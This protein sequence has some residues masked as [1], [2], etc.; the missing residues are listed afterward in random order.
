MFSA[1]HLHHARVPAA[2][3]AGALL[4]VAVFGRGLE[5]L[6]HFDDVVISD[7]DSCDIIVSDTTFGRP[8]DAPLLVLLSDGAD[9]FEVIAAGARGAISRNSSPSR[10]HAA[11]QAIGEGLIV[12]DR[13]PARDHRTPLIDPLTAREQDVL[14]L[15]A[16]GL[17]NKEIAS[18][19]GITDHTVKFHV[20]AIL[21]KL[22]AE[23]RTEA[24]VHAAKLGIVVL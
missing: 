23:T 8:F 5:E 9:A 7:I 16:A 1:S 15:L 3:Q 12:I 4:R 13:E 19:L 21:A 2:P 24:V 17:T 20:N 14:S 18:R 10:I 22:G 11:L 6:L